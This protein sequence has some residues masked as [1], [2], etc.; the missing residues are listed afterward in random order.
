MCCLEDWS[1][2]WQKNVD[3]FAD[4]KNH[5]VLICQKIMKIKPEKLIFL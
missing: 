4:S 1:Y 5:I 2:F 3:E